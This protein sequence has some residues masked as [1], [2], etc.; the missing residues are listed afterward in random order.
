M[1]TQSAAP[2]LQEEAVRPTGG[3]RRHTATLV[4]IAVFGIALALAPVA[5]QMFS[6]APKGAVMLADFKPFM[7]TQRLNGFDTD[8]AQIRGAV[9]SINAAHPPAAAASST[10]QTFAAQ[11]PAIDSTMSDLLDKVQANKGNY[12]AVA[13]LPSFRLFPW[14]FVIPGVLIAAVAG[15]ALWRPR[16]AGSARVA[17]IA[18]AIG[19]IL[20]PVAFQMF[21]RAPKGGRMMTAFSSIETDAKVEQIQQYFSSMAVGQG[22]IRLD[23]EPALVRTGHPI[24][25]VTTLDVN[26]VHILND[27]TP[28]IGAMSD[29]VGNYQAIKALP[30][31]PLFPWFFVIPGVLVGGLALAGRARPAPPTRQ[32]DGAR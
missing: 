11:W 6:R 9:S 3:D 26:W 14:F 1:T 10:Y 16:Q 17:L 19:L 20:A 2:P 5:F 13:A 28:M 30:P 7:T 22:A 4:I 23:I 27:M 24:A 18:L 31:F 12:D 21:N 29:N 15:L 32:A 25:A 8:L